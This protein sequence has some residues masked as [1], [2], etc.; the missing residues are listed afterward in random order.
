MSS[1]KKALEVTGNVLAFGVLGIVFLNAPPVQE[2]VSQREVRMEIKASWH[3][4]VDS[5]PRLDNGTGKV[6]IVEFSDYECPFC[7][8][9]YPEIEAFLDAN[10]KIGV[11]YR[12]MPLSMHRRAEGAARAAVC[13]E[14]Q[15]RFRE[16]TRQLFGSTAWKE[17][18]DWEREAAAAGVPNVSVFADCLDSPETRAQVEA[19]LTMA[20]RLGLRGTPAFVYRGG[21]HRGALTTEVLADILSEFTDSRQP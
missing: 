19:D 4:L 12:H 15:D 5:A 9:T 20:S 11:A 18:G 3:E 14:N 21:I 1:L 7:Q 2:W 8:R 6:R 16:M 13:A 17:D 10:P